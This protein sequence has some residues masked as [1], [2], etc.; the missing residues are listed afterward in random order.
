[1]TE[2]AGRRAATRWRL[3]LGE[4][5]AAALGVELSADEAEM[6]ATLAALYEERRGAGRDRATR[7]P[8]GRAGGLGARRSPAGWA[9][10][11][12]T[13]RPASSR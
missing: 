2:R 5:A 9:T 3:L 1:M 13:S 12:P 11:G 10:S 6:D 4:P 8:D 7:R